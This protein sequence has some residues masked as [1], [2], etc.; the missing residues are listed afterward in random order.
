M[1]LRDR[2]LLLLGFAGAFRRSELVSLDVDDLEFSRAGLIVTLRK[3]KTD[4]EGRSRRLGIPYGSSEPTC[5][6]RSLQ[7]WLE[8]ARIVDGPVFRAL[9]R[10]Q[11]VQPQRLSDK[12]VALV[13][14]RESEGSWARSGALCRTLVAGGVGDE[15]RGG[16]R[17]RTGDHVPDRPPLG[18]HGAALHPRGFLV[19]QQ[20]GGDGGSVMPLPDFGVPA[21]VREGLPSACFMQ[22]DPRGP[23]HGA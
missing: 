4:Q 10:F 18:R 5:P 22:A 2:A 14:K 19:C 20:P 12:A 15:C 7:T 8:S 16:G 21:H 13:V 9:D 6:V 23:A 1:G 3:S 17:V 11:R